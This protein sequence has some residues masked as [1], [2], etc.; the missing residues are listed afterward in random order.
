MIPKLTIFN[1]FF[2]FLYE[3]SG[4][5]LLLLCIVLCEFDSGQIFVFFVDVMPQRS[6]RGKPKK[7]LVEK[8]I[9]STPHA[10]PHRVNPKLIRNFQFHQYL[11]LVFFHQ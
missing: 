6:G 8:E 9:A 1:I 11:N 4:Y 7:I 5:R 10:P 2:P 3:S